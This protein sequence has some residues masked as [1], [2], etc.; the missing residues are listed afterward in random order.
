MCRECRI[1]C[2][3]RLCPASSFLHGRDDGRGLKA[4]LTYSRVVSS[5][6]DSTLVAASHF[7]NVEWRHTVNASGM[8]CVYLYIKYISNKYKLPLDNKYVLALLSFRKESF[9]MML[10]LNFLVD[11]FLCWVTPIRQNKNYQI[12]K[13]TNIKRSIGDFFGEYFVFI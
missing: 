10:P 2:C 9:Y 3:L 13:R 6:L 1:D 5:V 8:F 12:N 7:L 11:F 4:V